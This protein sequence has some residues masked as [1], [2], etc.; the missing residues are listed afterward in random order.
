MARTEEVNR[1]I[2]EKIAY[3]VNVEG[4]RPDRATAAAFRMYREGELIIPEPEPPIKEDNEE[5]ESDFRRQ[6][7][8]NTAKAKK[9]RKEVL[10]QFQAALKNLLN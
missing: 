6:R 9:K 7:R 10:K 4:L 2:S 5:V 1:A 8:L 3:L